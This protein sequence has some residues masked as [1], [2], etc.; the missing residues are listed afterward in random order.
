MKKGLKQ[1]SKIYSVIKG[2]KSFKKRF[3]YLRHFTNLI[4]QKRDKKKNDGI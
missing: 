2:Y 4:T 1:S 3:N